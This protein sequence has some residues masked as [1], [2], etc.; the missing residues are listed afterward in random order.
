MSEYSS[1]GLSEYS[2]PRLSQTGRTVMGHYYADTA[3]DY[4]GDSTPGAMEFRVGEVLQK[5]KDMGFGN[6]FEV[7][8]VMSESTN[9]LWR[10]DL[11]EFARSGGLND[12][13]ERCRQAGYFRSINKRRTAD[14]TMLDNTADELKHSICLSALPVYQA[15]W[16]ALTT[17]ASMKRPLHL[18]TET[19]IADFSF[20]A[21]YYRM[22]ELAPC[23]FAL[24]E[25]LVWRD[26]DDTVDLRAP[27]KNKLEREQRRH[28]RYIVMAVS[29]LAHLHTRRFNLVQGIMSI[30][31]YAHQVPKRVFPIFNHLGLA[32]SFDTVNRGLL[33]LA[34]DCRN[35]LKNMYSKGKGIQ[36]SFDNMQK[37]R[38]VRFER[39][40]NRGGLITGTAG[41]IAEDSQHAQ[42]TRQ[43]VNYA[44]VASMTIA[45]LLPTQDDNN[46]LDMYI[47]FK[48]SAIFKS[49]CVANGIAWKAE[50][51][52]HRPSVAPL[53]PKQSAKIHPLPTYALDEGRIDDVI[54][55]YDR[56]ASDVGLTAEQ[57]TNKVILCKGDY[58][59]VA[60]SR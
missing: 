20:G 56:I 36:I 24:F 7:V 39:Q 13:Y 4:L 59:T 35:T 54:R 8:T 40:H 30:Y 27:A 12:V 15:E 14:A 19:T 53:D 5:A 38:N 32:A 10:R 1:Q 37:Q 31:L 9:Q 21:I 22:S 25:G 46:I 44:A 51:D 6:V 60:N 55:I 3:L 49:W 50:L 29:V 58:M 47:Q 28:C 33:S 45:D 42:F 11:A 52:V 57:I 43:D 18:F 16:K 17:N 23:L 41:F 2:S 26:R 34:E 48:L